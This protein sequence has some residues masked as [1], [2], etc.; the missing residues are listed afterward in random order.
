MRKFILV[1]IL[2]LVGITSVGATPVM[3]CSGHHHHHSHHKSAK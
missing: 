1:A 2:A 3:A